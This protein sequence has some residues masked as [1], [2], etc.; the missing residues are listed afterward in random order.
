M[1][2]A[3]K[4][5][6]VSLSQLASSMERIVVFMILSRTLSQT[7]YGTY[8][9]VWLYYLTILP[10]FTLGLPS[11]LLYFIPKSDLDK[12]KTVVFQTLT[13]LEIVGIFFCAITFFSAPLMAKQFNNPDLVNYMRIFAFYPLF[14]ISPKLLNILMIANDK[15]IASAI[16]SFT[17]S[18]ITIFFI[19]LPSL[20]RLPLV[21]TFF[22]A[23]TGGI[24]YF[25]IFIIY[26]LGYYR[27]QKIFW[28]WN[29]FKEQFIYSIPLGV[30]SIMGTIS[31]QLNRLVVS[32]SFSTEMFAIFTNGAFEIPVIGLVTGSIMTVLIPEF[33]KRLQD[34]NSMDDVWHLWNNATIKTAIFL[35]PSAIFLLFFSQ[36]VMVT[37]FSSKYSESS[38]IFRIYLLVT[39][40]RI[41]QY[42]SLLQSM[43]KT[44]LI[45]ATSI[46]GLIINLILSKIS[47]PLFGLSGPAWANTITVYMWALIYLTII[48]NMLNI[49]FKKMMPWWQLSKLLII[50]VIAGIIVL[51]I[52]FLQTSPLLRLLIGFPIYCVAYIGLLLYL[53]IID[54]NQLYA[55]LNYFQKIVQNKFA[56]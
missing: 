51:P 20:I 17:Y 42:G 8:Q 33:V 30:S 54:I 1:K 39:F 22:G 6:I 4:V 16:S 13:I 43:G 27:D 45:L 41:T 25:T 46:M 49:S 7:E 12:K 35:F 24:I 37:L 44:N 14:S 50:S 3:F 31:V 9:Q 5:A 28:D 36:D 10:L 18:V 56:G 26:I 47:I 29:L 2:I 23:I 34:N 32:S 11:S 19:T 53:K 15:P 40:V 55:F 21:Y 52:N 48:H 38:V